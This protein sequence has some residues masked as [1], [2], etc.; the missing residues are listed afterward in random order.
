MNILTIAAEVAPYAK[1]GG[2]GDVAAGLPRALQARGHDVRVVLPGYR[3]IDRGRYGFAPA[4]GPYAVH[5]AAGEHWFAVSATTGAGGAGVPTY[6]VEFDTLFHRAHIYGYHDDVLRF[7]FLCQAALVM[8]RDE[9]YRP[10]IVHA[11]DWH[12]GYAL[13]WLSTAGRADDFYRNSAGVLT[14]H[15]AA[16]QG[17]SAWE[18]AVYGGLGA[19]PPLPPWEAPGEVNWLARGIAHADAVSAVSPRFAQELTMPASGWG[20]DGLLRARGER[21]VGILNGIDTE[22]WDPARDPQ[23]AARFSAADLEPRAVNKAALQQRLGLPVRPEAALIAFVGRLDAQKGVEYMLPALEALLEVQPD[24][25][26]VLLGSGASLY[27]FALRDLAAA[28]PQQVGLVLGFSAELAPLFY[29][30]CDIFLMPS[31]FE[32]CGLGQMIAMRYGAVPVVRATGGLA[33]TVADSDPFAA[34]P[35]AGTGFHFADADPFA[36]GFALDRA[37]RTY[38]ADPALWRQIQLNAI[39]QDFSWQ[40]AAGAYEALYERARGW[41]G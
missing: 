30:G 27:E 18:T 12:T 15:N 13:T 6:L 24:V 29:A 35:R 23:L 17:R 32:P 16:H 28:Y 22:V 5:N 10:D 8:A 37:V 9:G 33:D 21:L 39:A 14:V 34:P 41:H 11:H 3:A 25:Q 4:G 36:V 20:L 31:L 2:L 40:R 26:F 7:L 19:L 1:V 38:R